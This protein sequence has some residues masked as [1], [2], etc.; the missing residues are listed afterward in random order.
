MTT[1]S[2]VTVSDRDKAYFDVF[3]TA[4]EG[5]INYWAI[6]KGYHWRY[7]DED[8][9]DYD[10]YYAIISDEDEPFDGEPQEWRITRATI[11]KGVTLFY[12]YAIERD[13]VGSYQT[14]AAIALKKGKWDD[15]DFDA[16][17]ADVIVQL[18]LFGEVVFG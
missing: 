10:G 16:D 4:I 18:A 11:A 14:M 5:G 8:T 3:V 12:E 1:E 2:N 7:D 9:T 17:T 13:N 15:L 6:T